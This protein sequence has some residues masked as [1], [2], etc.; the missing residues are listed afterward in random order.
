MTRQYIRGAVASMLKLAGA[1][2][3][4][5]NR[6]L[7]ISI[8]AVA[9]CCGFSSRAHFTLACRRVCGVTPGEGEYRRQLYVQLLEAE[10]GCFVALPCG[11]NVPSECSHT[12]TFAL[13]TAALRFDELCNTGDRRN[14]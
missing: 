12:A 13:T 1:V 6:A 10:P 3:A 7:E 11:A 9:Y 4:S 2:G 14:R 5:K 8:A